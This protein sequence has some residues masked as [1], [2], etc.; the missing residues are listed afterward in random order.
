VLPGSSHI[1]AGKILLGLLVLW[2]FLFC[3]IFPFVNR[4][5]FPGSSLISHGVISMISVLLAMVIYGVSNI[6]T[7]RGISKGWL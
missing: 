6:L 2:P 3:M 7:R 4:Y 5:F 1:Y